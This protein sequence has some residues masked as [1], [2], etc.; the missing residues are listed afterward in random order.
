MT[1]QSLFSLLLGSLFISLLLFAGCSVNN[2]DFSNSGYSIQNDEV[3]LGE[4][5]TEKNQVITVQ[6][7]SNV[8][9]KRVGPPSFSLTLVADIDAP[10]VDG[11]KTQATMVNIFRNS[12]RAAV[13]YNV[14]GAEYVGAVDALQVTSSPD[15]NAISVKSGIQFTNAKSNALF[16]NERNIWIAQATN[17]PSIT[18]TGAN[19]VAR[20]FGLTG[21]RIDNNPVHKS[22]R[23]FA[24]NSIHESDEILYITS[25]SNAGLTLFS[26][27]LSG[28]EIEFIDIPGA[29]WVDTDD[30]RIVVLASNPDTETGTLHVLAKSDRSILHQHTFDG[31]FI[32]EAKNTVE[33]K[34]DLAVVSAGYSGTH[35][36]DIITGDIIATIALPDAAALGLSANEVV[37]NAASADDEFIF[38]SNG[39]AG[40]YVAEASDDLDSYS[41]G[42]QLSVDVLGYLEFDDSQSANHVA[43]RNGTLFVAAGLGGVKAV[44][45]NRPCSNPVTQS[46]GTISI[47]NGETRCLNQEFTGNVFFESGGILNVT[48]T[49]QLQSIYGNQPGVINISES[50]DVEIGNWNNN[51]SS[52][53][54]NNWGKLTFP[55]GW[56]TI[57]SGTLTN[58]G[59]LFIQGGLSQNNGPIINHG[60]MEVSQSVNLNIAGNI[61]N[62]TFLIGSGLTL[63]SASELSNS[64]RMEMS[65]TFVV[66]SE[67]VANEGSFTRANG[68]LTVNSGGLL[69]QNGNDGM[70]SSQSVVLNGS[71][72]NNGSNNLLLVDNDLNSNSGA[73]ITSANN[74]LG[75]VASNFAALPTSFQ[76]TDGSSFS[77]AA[78]TCNPSGYN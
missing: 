49:V 4:R 51:Y 50:G 23:G 75:V 37:S 54:I 66:N 63:N 2:D 73:S 9:E 16:M 74:P 39:E 22:V 38:I 56:V 72:S 34:G 64:C 76:I 36:I 13:S 62:G 10:V 17:D 33:I 20:N 27:D 42:D 12:A 61:N 28:E 24:A 60:Q 47:R 52:D 65:G 55:T 19:S 40:V 45:L 41:T 3:K 71:I 70:V 35:L 68:Q 59:D 5:L 69:N 77:I 18:N 1:H 44:K 46:S 30:N 57:N 14:Q 25:G 43:Y 15:F 31:I 78:T 48:S 21:F 32:P 58:H 67:Y 26:S 53:A 11:V 6:S 7:T 29:R 8:S